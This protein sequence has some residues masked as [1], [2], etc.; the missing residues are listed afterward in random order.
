MALQ[1]NTIHPSISFHSNEKRKKTPYFFS[2]I[3]QDLSVCVW[4]KKKRRKF[5][6]HTHAK[7][8]YY[9]Y[10]NFNEWKIVKMKMK[11]MNNNKKMAIQKWRSPF[12]L[13]ILFSTIKFRKKT[14]KT[15][16][17]FFTSYDDDDD[18]DNLHDDVLPHSYTS[19]KFN[20]IH[21]IMVRLSQQY[22]MNWIL[23]I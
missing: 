1:Q 22:P 6:T 23:K 17:E 3:M 11:M 7:I 14:E 13:L 16:T 21:F 9:W 10:V 18:D 20:S 12:Y 15:E 5:F 19:S 4:R 2:H 8:Y